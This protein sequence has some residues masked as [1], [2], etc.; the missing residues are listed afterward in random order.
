MSKWALLKSALRGKRDVDSPVSIHT[1]TGF[2]HLLNPQK[3]IWEG[4]EFDFML[5]VGKLLLS[6]SDAA[7]AR[8]AEEAGRYMESVDCAEC[9]VNLCHES[10]TQDT[11]DEHWAHDFSVFLAD[12]FIPAAERGGCFCL[13][14]FTAAA[15]MPPTANLAPRRYAK[16]LASHS[17]LVPMLPR[18]EYLIYHLPSYGVVASAPLLARERPKGMG[19]DS[20]G[21]LSN[22]L[23]D[24]IDNT[25]NVR[26]WDAEQILLYYLTKLPLKL[27][28]KRLLEL[29]GGMTG[30]CG[31]GLARSNPTVAGIVI[32]DVHP[33][34]IRNP[35]V[36]IEMNKSFDLR[37][38]SDSTSRLGCIRSRLLRWSIDD[39]Y[40]D[41]RGVISENGAGVLFDVILAADCLFFRDFQDDLLWTLRTALACTGTVYLL[42]PLRGDSMRSFVQKAEL[43]FTVLEV[44]DFSPEI[45]RE[46][47]TASL[48]PTAAGYNPDVHLPILLE[49]KKKP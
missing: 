4:F 31:L 43:Y 32:T 20:A 26:V 39:K 30:L 29:G 46:I 12:V 1:F 40:G 37:A 2:D 19:V 18:A 7:V 22:I 11:I 34:C 28:G 38:M 15:E 16:L 44:L 47:A 10:F 27:E 45:T 48:D 41:L 9:M 33:N 17:S 8:L 3:T 24:G 42:Q 49:M 23:H 21:L 25:G 13:L 6:D 14:H 36:C 35:N 5:N